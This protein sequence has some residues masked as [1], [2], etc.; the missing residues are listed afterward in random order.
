VLDLGAGEGR[1]S[2]FLASEGFRVDAVD[3]SSVAIQHMLAAATERDLRVRCFL[4]DIRTFQPPRKTYDALLALG[5]VPDLLLSEARALFGNIGRWTRPG[6]LVFASAFTV[7]HS[8]Y[9]ETRRTWEA[10]EPNSFRSPEGRVRTFLDENQILE[11]LPDFD[12]VHHEE[13][14]G[15]PHRHGKGPLERHAFARLVARRG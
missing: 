10:V 5:L 14:I 1:N 8:K 13:G 2:L 15:V 12:V 11:L 6:G 4:V 7:H 3:V 9:E